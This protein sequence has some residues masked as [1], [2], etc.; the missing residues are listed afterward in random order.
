MPRWLAYTLLTLTALFWGGTTVAAR[1][2]AGDIPPFSLTF[3]RWTI[4]FVL[5]IPIGLAP[6]WRQRALFARHWKMMVGYSFLGIVGFT[7]CYFVGLTMTTAINASLLNGALPIMIVVLSL[8][9]LGTRIR[10]I[11]WFGIGLAL[12]G[13]VIIVLRGE[14]AR[15][16]QV[17]LNAGDLFLLLA[18]LSWAFYTICLRWLPDGI[19]ANALILVLSALAVPML[20]PFYLWE[21][22][23]GETFALSAGNI[24]LILYTAVFSSV[25]AYLF[26]NLGV[27]AVGANTAGFSH[28]LIP[29][30]GTVGSVLLLGETI[31]TFHMVAIALIFGGPYF[32]TTHAPG[33]GEHP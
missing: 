17:C 19:D 32:A 4:A 12:A 7:I 3:W 10:R 26:W 25:L 14:M 27:A 22:A 6:W 9:M 15:I 13:S 5:F 28:Y 16:T 31:E 20:A 24:S 21:L 2:A 8:A 33:N 30:F 23:H 29:V 11:Q 1:A 18:M